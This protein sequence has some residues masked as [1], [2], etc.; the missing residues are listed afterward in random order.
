MIKDASISAYLG[1][2]ALVPVHRI[3]LPLSQVPQKLQPFPIFKA[4]FLP[5]ASHLSA[6]LNA[7]AL[8]HAAPVPSAQQMTPYWIDALDLL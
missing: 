7:A 6:F 3:V 4:S 8:P 2:K 5:N 1:T